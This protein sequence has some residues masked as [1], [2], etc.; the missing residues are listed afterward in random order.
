MLEMEFKNLSL[1]IVSRPRTCSHVI[2][3]SLGGLLLKD[4]ITP[5]TMFPV[6]VGPPGFDRTLVQRGRPSPRLGLN[7]ASSGKLEDIAEQLFYIV[8]E[9]KP[10]Q[11]GCDYR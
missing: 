4:K 6:L 10:I 7:S 3:L 5:N 2:E 9:K 1:N 8:Y 11:A